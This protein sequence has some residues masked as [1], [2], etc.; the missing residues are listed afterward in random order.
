[1][2][3]KIEHI[4][5]WTR[6]L[7]VMKNFYCT[8]FQAIS[9]PLYHNP[10][11]GFS[12]YFLTVT[13]GTRLELCYRPDIIEGVK[14]SFGFAHLAFSLG[15]KEAVDTFAYKMQ[16]HGFYLQNGPR[17]TGDGY[18]EAVILDPEGNQLELTI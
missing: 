17:V 13:D 14:D 7:E 2:S 10:E 18:Y 3:M 8:Y 4:G 11:S 15:S 12:S 9:S 1:M 5:L 16:E 6:D